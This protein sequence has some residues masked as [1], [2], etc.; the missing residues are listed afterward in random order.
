MARK[1]R[2]RWPQRH[3]GHVPRQ[4]GGRA[5]PGGSSW[6]SLARGTG[7]IET[8]YLNGEIVLLGRLYGVATPVNEA[9]QGLAGHL[10]DQGLP[11]GA[12]SPEE[13]RVRLGEARSDVG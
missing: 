10:A 6:Q 12:L 2:S 7:Q 4:I 11:P 1:K 8:D 5:F 9:L 3:A 13:L